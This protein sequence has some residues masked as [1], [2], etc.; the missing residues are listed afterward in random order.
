MTHF[1][2]DVESPGERKKN[3]WAGPFWNHSANR[4][5]SKVLI[6]MGAVGFMI[7]PLYPPGDSV[8][9]NSLLLLFVLKINSNLPD[10]H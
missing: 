5:Q 3:R 8:R 7:L 10:Y 4:S 9:A 6:I 2:G 1:Y